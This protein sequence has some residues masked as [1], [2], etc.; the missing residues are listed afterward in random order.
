[1]RPGSRRRP[2]TSK[3]EDPSRLLAVGFVW[4]PHGVAGELSVEPLGDSPDLFKAGA[5]LLWI[6]GASVRELKLSSKRLHGK[7]LLLSF[8]GI[9]DREEA[10]RLSAGVLCLP[11]DRLPRMPEDFYWSHELEGWTCEDPSGQPLGTVRRLDQ[12][13]AGGQLTLATPGG[14]EVLVPFVRPIVVAVDR[15]SRRIVLDP[16]EGLMQL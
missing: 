16:P 14:R 12:T 3:K 9:G 11:A 5:T 7:R 13:V 4:R 6:A 8:E 2:N 1:L 10:D 15:A